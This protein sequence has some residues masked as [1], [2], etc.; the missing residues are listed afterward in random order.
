MD[1]QQITTF[2]DRWQKSGGAERANYQLFLTELC[3]VLGVPH[4]QPTVAEEPANAYVFEKNVVFNN[5]DGSFSTRRID[6]YH[7]G[8]FICETKQG[9]EAHDAELLFSERAQEAR[10]KRK[11]GHGQRGTKSYDDTMLHARGQAEQYARNLPTTEGRPPFLM[12]IDVAKNQ[13]F[14]NSSTR[15]LHSI[16]EGIRS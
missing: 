14:R 10:K 12:V 11:S 5:N 6:L 1:P 16:R 8:A 9:V 15:Q 4:P 2:I 3:D 13:C 7:R